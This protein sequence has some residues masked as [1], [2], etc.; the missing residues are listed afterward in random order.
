MLQYS[1]KYSIFY[2]D[3]VNSDAASLVPEQ[4]KLEN[5]GKFSPG[6]SLI[7]SCRGVGD[8]CRGVG[9]VFSASKPFFTERIASVVVLNKIQHDDK[10]KH[11]ARVGAYETDGAYFMHN[12]YVIS[13]HLVHEFK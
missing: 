12:Y 7:S 4:C 2:K 6:I 9:L 1:S 5:E 11:T 8:S 10:T 3:N 13:N